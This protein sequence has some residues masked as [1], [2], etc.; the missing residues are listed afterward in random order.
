MRE[1]L[2]EIKSAIKD[3]K[4]N[5]NVLLGFAVNNIHITPISFVSP[6]VPVS[7]VPRYMLTN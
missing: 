4:C 2:E 1:K 6:I 7:Q 5:Y 3:S